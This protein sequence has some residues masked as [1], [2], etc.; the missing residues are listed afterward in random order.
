MLI[1]RNTKTRLITMLLQCNTSFLPGYKTSTEKQ[2]SMHEQMK[3]TTI[4]TWYCT[5][6][7]HTLYH[8]T[9]RTIVG[10]IVSFLSVWKLQGKKKYFPLTNA[11]TNKSPETD[12]RLILLSQHSNNMELRSYLSIFFSASAYFVYSVNR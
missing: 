1:Y 9:G 2:M 5:Y 7:A 12:L 6:P 3:F 4:S 8:I 11:K 10:K